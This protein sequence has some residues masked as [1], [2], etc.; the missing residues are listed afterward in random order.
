MN[1]LLA[2]HGESPSL[3]GRFDG[4][5]YFYRWKEKDRILIKS[6]LLQNWGSFSY[7]RFKGYNYFASSQIQTE[8]QTVTIQAYSKMAKKGAVDFWWLQKKKQEIQIK[9]KGLY[10]LFRF[11][12]QLNLL[13]ALDFQYQKFIVAHYGDPAYQMK[14]V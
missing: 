3:I 2:R 14:L 1:H 9:T 7:H 5:K 12:L 6:L 8:I 11:E 13:W 4:W 10:Q